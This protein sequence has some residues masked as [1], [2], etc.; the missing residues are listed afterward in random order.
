M[1]S[2]AILLLGLLTCASAFAAQD[3]IKLTRTYKVGDSDKYS[4]ALNMSSAMGEI[5]VKTAM[6]QKVIKVYDNGDADIETTI[7]SMSVNA[8]G[9]EMSPPAPAPTTGRYNKFGTQIDSGKATRNRMGFD[10][11][12]YATMVSE[13]GFKVGETLQIDYKDPDNPKNTSKGTVKADSVTDGI[14]KLLVNLDVTNEQTGPDKPMH[15]VMTTFANVSNGKATKVD[16]V[17]TNLPAGANGPQIE[18][19]TLVLTLEK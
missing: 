19:M 6:T 1:R 15:I 18:K 13:K 9:N 3:V 11:M 4:M 14:V 10:F 5:A 12:K 8:M 7:T 17:I 16:G 2:K